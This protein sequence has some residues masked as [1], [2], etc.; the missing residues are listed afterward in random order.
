MR[1]RKRPGVDR[2]SQA[3]A[4]RE[5][6]CLFL[7]EFV[8]LFFDGYLLASVTPVKLRGVIARDSSPSRSSHQ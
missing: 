7:F 8:M 1:D 6:E 2:T 4:V 5:R 3:A